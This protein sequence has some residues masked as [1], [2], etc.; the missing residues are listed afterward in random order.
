MALL[1]LLLPSEHPKVCPKKP[2]CQRSLTPIRKPRRNAAATPLKSALRKGGQS[3][4]FGSIRNRTRRKNGDELSEE[5]NP[6]KKKMQRIDL[7]EVKE[8]IKKLHRLQSPNNGP[9]Q[10]GEDMS[11]AANGHSTN[12]AAKGL[13]KAARKMTGLVQNT[14]LL[15]SLA[16]H[17][18]FY[19]SL[20]EC[21]SHMDP[22]NKLQ[23]IP[24][25]GKHLF[26][27]P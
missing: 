1:S 16:G 11:T 23:G 8:I 15:G 21:V 26:A 22:G 4:P 7:K 6:F 10:T 14:I 2:D 24:A 27:A 13:Q 17:C 3:R 19:P 12:Q 18:H 9:L 25:W 20:E 5:V